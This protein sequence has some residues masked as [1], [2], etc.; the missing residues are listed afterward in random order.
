[1]ASP[2]RTISLPSGDQIPGV[3]GGDDHGHHLRP[4]SDDDQ[5]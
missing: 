2:V 4:I 3:A 5:V 1:M